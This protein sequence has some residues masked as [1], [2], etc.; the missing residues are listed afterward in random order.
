LEYH[1][2]RLADDHAAATKIGEACRSCEPFSI[3]AGCVDTNI[4]IVEID[5]DWGDSHRLHRS[6]AERGVDCFAIGP[7]AIRF[8]TH[9]DV[10]D[11]QIDEAC[12]IIQSIGADV[13]AR[14]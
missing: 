2:D 10:S 9:L 1:R 13:V 14:T 7:Q 4:V 12:Q 3:R 11:A 6:L 8:V 5:S